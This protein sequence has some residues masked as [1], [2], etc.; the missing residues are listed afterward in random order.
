MVGWVLLG[1]VALAGERVLLALPAG[2]APPLVASPDF[3]AVATVRTDGGFSR[4]VTPS[5]TF[6]AQTAIDP[7]SLVFNADGSKLAYRAQTLAGWRLLVNGT[8]AKNVEALGTP[9]FAGIDRLAFISKDGFGAFVIRNGEKEPAYDAICDLRFSADGAHLAY[10]AG[11]LGAQRVVLDGKAGPV[12]HRVASPCV[13]NDG[14]TLA[15]AAE[16]GGKWRL[17]V[18]GKAGPGYEEVLDPV[19]SADG[20]RVA[21]ISGKLAGFGNEEYIEYRAV[22]DGKV[23]PPEDRASLPRFSAD[24]TRAGYVAFRVAPDGAGG[25]SYLMIDGKMGR[26]EADAILDWDFSPDGAHI[27]VAARTGDRTS[28]WIDGKP[29]PTCEALIPAG[30]RFFT[31]DGHTLR[32]LARRG[33]QVVQVEVEM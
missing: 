4:A 14:T 16:S 10:I 7:A 20:R 2:K 19:L 6:G 18:N 12:Y 27:V 33:T 5:K 31:I 25:V 1:L 24:G 9:A 13:N 22:I 21:Y 11:S 15:Y 26:E 28:L 30:T 32:Y 17:M 23:G 3:R 29:G 8:M